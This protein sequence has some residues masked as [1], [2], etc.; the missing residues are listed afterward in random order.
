[1]TLEGW[2]NP[3]GSN[4][5]EHVV[6][7][8]NNHPQVANMVHESTTT[9]CKHPTQTTNSFVD[10]RKHSVVHDF[11]DPTPI[12]SINASILQVHESIHAPGMLLGA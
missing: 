2:Q 10:H 11:T 1:L 4:L 5:L 3:N 8:S 12:T 6:Y 9:R 7:D